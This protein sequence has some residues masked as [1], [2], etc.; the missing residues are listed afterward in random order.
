MSDALEA[1]GARWGKQ[2]AGHR[3]APNRVDAT[4][5]ADIGSA[6]LGCV[7]GIGLDHEL[8]HQ[9]GACGGG[10]RGSGPRSCMVPPQ[11][12]QTSIAWPVS[13]RVRSR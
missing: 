8:S 11:S 1:V 12:G 5:D 6:W 2:S 4:A 3:S 13:R 7:S 10:R 9:N